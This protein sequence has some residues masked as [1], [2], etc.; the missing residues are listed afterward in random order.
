MLLH[1][2]PAVLYQGAG[3]L[4]HVPGHGALPLT[5]TVTNMV[6]TKHQEAPG[7]PSLGQLGVTG[8]KM[9]GIAENISIEKYVR[10]SKSDTN[11]WARNTNPLTGPDGRQVNVFSFLP[12]PS[13]RTP[14]SIFS[15][16]ADD[17]KMIVEIFVFNNHILS[18]SKLTFGVYSYNE[19]CIVF[20]I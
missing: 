14:S 1:L 11:P 19:N 20:T 12:L 4:L 16:P 8:D 6:V 3:E 2:L 7:P 17:L 9:L 18:K 13:F 10:Q 15:V 5:L